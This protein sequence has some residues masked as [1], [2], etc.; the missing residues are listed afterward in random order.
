MRPLTRAIA[1][2]VTDLPSPV[3][4]ER[5]EDRAVRTGDAMVK[6]SDDPDDGGLRDALASIRSRIPSA[7]VQ[8]RRE[9]RALCMRFPD[10]YWRD[11][12]RRR[13]YPEAFVRALTE[14]GW[15]AALIPARYGGLGYG[16]QEAAAILQ[17][18]NQSGAYAGPA[19]A[20]MY[21]MGALLRHGSE[22]QKA[23]VP[24][25]IA[26]WCAAPAGVRG[27]GT[28]GRNRH[29]PH[30]DHRRSATATTTSSPAARFTSLACSTPI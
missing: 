30:R 26:V 11:L 8:L 22:E 13:E 12:D 24:A 28:D 19:H 15:L 23:A 25:R 14:A 29:D 6:E 9:I 20:Q 3:A 1:V 17:E 18:I 21:V 2:S 5:R 4:E 27:H 7:S 16:L 10:A